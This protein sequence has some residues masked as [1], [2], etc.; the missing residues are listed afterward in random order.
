MQIAT[1]GYHDHVYGQGD[2]ADGISKQMWGFV[3]GETWTAVWHQTLYKHAS[4]NANGLVLFEKGK[5][6]VIVEAAGIVKLSNF[7]GRPVAHALPR[8]HRDAR[9]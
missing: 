7:P 1:L 4:G 8:Q 5:K 9:L 6:S 3:Q 2:L